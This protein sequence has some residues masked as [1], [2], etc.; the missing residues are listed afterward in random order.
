MLEKRRQTTNNADA[1]ESVSGRVKCGAWVT[2]AGEQ[3][4]ERRR[5]LLNDDLT[6]HAPIYKIDEFNKKNVQKSIT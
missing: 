2:G 4:D 5:C 1:T 6:N 3:S